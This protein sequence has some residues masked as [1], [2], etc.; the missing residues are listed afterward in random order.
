MY[1]CKLCIVKSCCTSWC[2]DIMTNAHQIAVHIISTN[3]CPDCGEKLIR[4]PNKKMYLCISCT[5]VFIHDDVDK[6]PKQ[7]LNYVRLV[8]LK[9][10]KHEKP[11]PGIMRLGSDLSRY[12]IESINS[13][14]EERLREKNPKLNPDRPREGATP[15]VI[16]KT[17]IPT[18][19]RYLRIYAQNSFIPKVWTQDD[20]DRSKTNG[21]F[22]IKKSGRWVKHYE[23]MY[24]ESSYDGIQSV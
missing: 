14:I 18:M 12:T 5:K 13:V 19:S 15:T 16:H 9:D 11:D 8:T 17:T 20:L 2:D 4:K 23:S 22:L 3:R 21:D 7:G 10:M 6:A 24:S 1:P